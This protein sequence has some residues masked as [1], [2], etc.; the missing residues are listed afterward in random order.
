[1]QQTPVRPSKRA[2]QRVS[3]RDVDEKAGVSPAAVS[4]TLSGRG[5]IADQTRQLI[6]RTVAELKYVLPKRRR[7]SADWRVFTVSAGSG[8]EAHP[9]RTLDLQ[10]QVR[11]LRD[12]LDQRQQEGCDTRR[13]E[14]L[15][16][17]LSQSSP[18]PYD[19]ETALD[20]I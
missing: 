2:P 18:T 17:A 20:Q 11:L 12:E 6:L 15:V 19:I 10:H 8:S 5:R 4:L 14:P 1:M 9:A 7:E 3:I 16:S 13:I